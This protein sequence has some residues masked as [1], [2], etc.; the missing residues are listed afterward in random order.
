[1]VLWVCVYMDMCIYTKATNGGP[2]GCVLGP[3]LLTLYGVCCCVITNHCYQMLSST[4]FQ[5]IFHAKS[6]LSW[7]TGG[8]SP[9]VFLLILRFSACLN[10]WYQQ[11]DRLLSKTAYRLSTDSLLITRSNN[12][13]IDHRLYLWGKTTHKTVEQPFLLHEFIILVLWHKLKPM[14]LFDI[15]LHWLENQCI[16]KQKL[17]PVRELY[18]LDGTWKFAVSIRFNFAILSKNFKWKLDS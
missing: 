14:F 17:P 16:L 4:R 2:Q 6:L 18:S 9:P 8:Q 13:I 15:I 12:N 10:C 11:P 3:A 5:H 1:M 7:A